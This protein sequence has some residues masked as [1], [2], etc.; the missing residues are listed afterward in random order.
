M[1]TINDWSGFSFP[2][3]IQ[4]W[5]D[6]RIRARLHWRADLFKYLRCKC[7]LLVDVDIFVCKDVSLSNTDVIKLKPSSFNGACIQLVQW[8]IDMNLKVKNI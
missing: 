2:N 4:T 7:V 8:N 1:L 6:I 3:S 5:R